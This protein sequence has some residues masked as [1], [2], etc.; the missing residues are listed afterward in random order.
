MML[1]LLSVLVV[2]CW[3]AR[4]VKIFQSTP[5]QKDYFWNIPTF[6]YFSHFMLTESRREVADKAWEKYESLHLFEWDEM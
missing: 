3:K 4:Q 6:C 1:E 5:E 2:I